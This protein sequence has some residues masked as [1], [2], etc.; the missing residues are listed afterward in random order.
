[1]KW[2]FAVN[3]H[4]LLHAWDQIQ[5]TVSSARRNTRLT[6]ICLVDNGAKSPEA[7]A[8]IEV[9]ARNGVQII[10]HKSLLWP[11]V[12]AKKGIET[13]MFSGHWLRCD[14]PLIDRSDEII[15]YTDIDVMFRS[16]PELFGQRPDFIACAPE[17][18][19]DDWGYFNSGVMLMNLQNLRSTRHE[20]EK[21]IENNI[22]NMA[23]HDDQGA[24]NSVYRDR[25]S[26]LDIVYNWKPY[27][28]FNVHVPIL[29]FHG[30]K[31]IHVK[32]YQDEKSD[33]QIFGPDLYSLY[34]RD[35]QAYAAY[36]EESKK[37]TLDA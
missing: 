26:K 12:K 25:W 2:Y 8:R 14:I 9:L 3:E 18:N 4:G 23:P 15:L 34:Q 17:F 19:Q 7:E 35:T 36:L 30:P 21:H 24:L 33:T 20:L 10:E 27:W 22:I 13:D 5:I 11:I 6:P 31:P 29:H 37:Y 28:G 32:V 1:M 16:N